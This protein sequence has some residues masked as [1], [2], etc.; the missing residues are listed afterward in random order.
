MRQSRRPHDR[1]VL[2]DSLEPRLLLARPLG[3]DISG[4]QPTNINWAQVKSGNGSTIPGRSFTYAKA[5]EGV[6]FSDSHFAGYV[7]GAHAAGMKIGAY[8]YARYDLGNSPVSEADYFVSVAAPAL[9]N[10]DLVPML[11]V[12]APFSASSSTKYNTKA[13]LSAWVNAW[14][15]E[16]E[17]KT[18]AVPI[19]YTY[20]S[21][22]NTYLD[23][24][25]SQTW[26]LWMANYTGGDPQTAGPSSTSVW[27]TW[28]L[29]QY[30]DNTSVY[31]LGGTGVTGTCDGDVLNGDLSTLNDYVIGSAGKWNDGATVQTNTGIKAWS[32]SAA[33]GTY[34]TEPTGAVGTILQG[35]VYGNGYQRWQ[36]RFKDGVVGWCAED[37]MNTVTTAPAAV[38]SPTPASGAVVFTSPASLSWGDSALATSFDVYLDGVL[39]TNTTARSYA[40]SPPVAQGSHSWRIVARN[41]AGTTP[42]AT[43]LFTITPLATPTLV[44][45]TPT[46]GSTM[47]V[48]WAPVDSR[49][50][51]V[52]LQRSTAGGPFVTIAL[53]IKTI[54]SYE[55]SGLSSG[56]VYAYRVQ[57]YQGTTNNS[58]WSVPGYA[59]ALLPGDANGDYSIDF[60]DTLQILG[61]G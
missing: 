32:S 30:A 40:L 12:E 15:N 61:N 28:Q 24:S 58:A 38:A 47:H 22:A 53:P 29:W 37:L 45:A 49:A 18:G 42:S 51:A 57:A 35:P 6:G 26:P 10:G 20:I 4:Y 17:L 44:A 5:T 31:G 41:S 46:S 14:C 48:T 39:K 60:N 9:H 56:T 43:W 59:M 11:D 34:I 2:I 27:Q 13:T 19:V 55:D 36:T 23:S 50:D 21:Y 52:R 8:H 33:N 1:F 25:V 16:V 3:I 7:S 54:T